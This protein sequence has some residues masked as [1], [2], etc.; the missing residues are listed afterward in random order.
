MYFNLG[1]F[2]DFA[3]GSVG[4]IMGSVAERRYSGLGLLREGRG[5][6]W[7]IWKYEGR[8]GIFMH[9]YF[10]CLKRLFLR[11][12]IRGGQNDTILNCR[13]LT[14]YRVVDGN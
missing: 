10:Y 11:K 12:M 3:Y 5:A 14:E 9:R 4:V 7:M 13:A 2:E 1:G 8:G 6:C